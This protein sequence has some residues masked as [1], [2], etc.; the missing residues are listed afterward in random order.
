M[1]FNDLRLHSSDR[2]QV[3]EEAFVNNN[4][5]IRLVSNNLETNNFET[6]KSLTVTDAI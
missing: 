2:I 4:I 6:N 5:E 1:R 3:G